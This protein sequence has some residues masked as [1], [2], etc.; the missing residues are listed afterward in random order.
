M[1][2][3]FSGSYKFHDPFWV[4]IDRA[5]NHLVPVCGSKV[6]SSAFTVTVSSD[7]FYTESAPITVVRFFKLTT[8]IDPTF[9]AYLIYWINFILCSQIRL[10]QG[11]T[12]WTNVMETVFAIIVWANATAST[13]MARSATWNSQSS[14]TSTPT[15]LRE[16]GIVLRLLGHNT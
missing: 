2:C 10:G 7:Y 14:T 12:R 4:N 8:C 9:I 1:I 6:N 15:V 3:F 11:V 13:A 16:R 5:C